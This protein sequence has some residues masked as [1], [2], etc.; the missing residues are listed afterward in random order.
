MSASPCI[1]GCP[2][3]ALWVN[4]CNS[5][6]HC[7]GWYHTSCTTRINV[8]TSS[9]EYIG[10]HAPRINVHFARPTRVQMIASAAPYGA[11][12]R[13]TRSPLNQA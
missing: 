13:N 12:P 9:L 6:S 5:L 11:G 8:A 3:T 2:A 7:A 4:P 1:F 10:D